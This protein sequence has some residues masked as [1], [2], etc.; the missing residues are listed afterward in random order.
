MVLRLGKLNVWSTY[1]PGSLKTVVGE[2]TK[3]VLGV[4]GM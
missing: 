4:I 3:C 1:R 2:S